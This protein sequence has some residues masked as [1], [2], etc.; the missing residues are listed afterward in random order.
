VRGGYGHFGHLSFSQQEPQEGVDFGAVLLPLVLVAL[1]EGAQ[2]G[3]VERLD[4]AEEG[5][6]VG[7][8]GEVEVREEILENTIC[9]KLDCYKSG[10]GKSRSGKDP[11]HM[12]DDMRSD[13]DCRVGPRKDPE[14]MS[15]DMGSQGPQKGLVDMND[16]VRSD[17][18]LRVGWADERE[19]EGE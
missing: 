3:L 19:G 10:Y 11:V 7:L 1:V 2:R 13:L 18:E 8:V 14:N 16:D 12:K 6:D 17:L 4:G 15:G 9:D 5:D